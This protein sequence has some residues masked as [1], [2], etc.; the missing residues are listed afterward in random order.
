M[1]Q[2]AELLHILLRHSFREERLHRVIKFKLACKEDPRLQSRHEDQLHMSSLQQP[3]E[4]GE[5]DQLLS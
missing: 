2:N 3:G 1:F 4:H 5:K